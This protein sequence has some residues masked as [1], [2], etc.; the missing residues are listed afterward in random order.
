MRLIRGARRF[1]CFSLCGSRRP[2]LADACLML[3]FR[4]RSESDGCVGLLSSVVRGSR[5]MGE[6]FALLPES[7]LL[8]LC[9]PKEEVTK[10]KG[11]PARRPAVASATSGCVEVWPGFSIG[12]PALIE[13]A[14]TSS[15]HRREGRG[16]SKADGASG[17]ALALAWLFAS[18]PHWRRRDEGRVFAGK[19]LE[20]TIEVGTR[21]QREVR[22]SYLPPAMSLMFTF[23]PPG[24]IMSPGFWSLAQGPTHLPLLLMS[25]SLRPITA[26]SYLTWPV[27]W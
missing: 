17:F 10:K 2:A 14:G 21:A 9:L 20:P 23:W 13:K 4:R 3:S 25:A 18:V 26:G 12:H 16:K 7:E 6:G 15:P 27:V 1:S 5:P 22:L 19:W 24:R 8:L 11:H